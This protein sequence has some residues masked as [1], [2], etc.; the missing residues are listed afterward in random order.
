MLTL[1]SRSHSTAGSAADVVEGEDQ[2]RM[3]GIDPR[4][5]VRRA[6]CEERSLQAAH[7]AMA[8]SQTRRRGLRRPRSRQRAT[9][10][11]SARLELRAGL[12]AGARVLLQRPDDRVRQ[13]RASHRR[14]A[15]PPAS[16]VRRGASKRPPPLSRPGRAAGRR[17]SRRRPPP[18]R[19]GRSVH[20]PCRLRPAPGSC[21]SGCRLPRPAPVRVP[22]VSPAMTR[23][24]PKSASMARPVGRSSRMFSG[25]TSRCTRPASP[26]AL[27]RVGE[28]GHDPNHL[29]HGEPAFP[30]QPLPETLPGDVVHHVVEQPGGLT[31][32]VHRH[33]ARVPQ[34]RD[35][36]GFG[37]EALGD[38]AVDGEIGVDHLHRDR[39]GRA[40]CPGPGRPPPCPRAPAPARGG[41]GA[42][43]PPAGGP[44]ALTAAV[45][46]CNSGLSA[47]D[48]QVARVASR[49]LFI[50]TPGYREGCSLRRGSLDRG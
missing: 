37:Q 35:H 29:R 25:F 34:P 16:A 9:H 45:T 17:A 42:R 31:G 8:P 14:G 12:P 40:W 46:L 6:E 2:D 4:R 41:T 27:Q 24:I 21:R 13:A 20:R 38:G 36:P 5:R 49:G 30:L 48:G 50:L 22:S 28:I 3:P 26:A 39:A 1:P 23:A 10:Q 19:R 32:A 18:G 11:C 43:A 47:G 44:S 15:S 7:S 33:D